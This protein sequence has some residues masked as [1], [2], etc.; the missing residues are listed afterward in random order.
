MNQADLLAIAMEADVPIILWGDPG[1][2]K[3]E[4]TYQIAEYQ[5]RLT[6]VELMSQA[7]PTDFGVPFVSD[8]HQALIK[9]RPM[10]VKQLQEAEK[11]CLFADEYNCAPRASQVAGHRMVREKIVG[12]AYLGAHVSIVLACNPPEMATSVGE[13]GPALANRLM[14]VNWTVDAH[15]WIE[16]TLGQSTNKTYPTLSEGWE[17]RIAQV[18]TGIAAF[19]QRRPQLLLAVPKEEEQQSRAWPSPRTWDLVARMIAAIESTGSDD[20]GEAVTG[21]IGAGTAQEFVVWR[22]EAD[23]PDP[24]AM[25]KDAEHCEL[26]LRGDHIYAVIYG[27]TQAVSEE[28][29]YLDAAWTLMD[30]IGAAGHV[31]AGSLTV[32]PLYKVVSTRKGS[33]VHLKAMKIIEKYWGELLK[34]MD[35]EEKSDVQ[36]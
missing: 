29:K 26:P 28:K 16:Y 4:M 1:S 2:G 25:L 10:W 12:D 34:R 18:K 11:G 15:S 7:D 32:V 14:H 6:H 9:L 22:A 24:I 23:L 8:E 21:L 19:I 31:D 36:T 30:R 20:I 3:S 35:H 33:E 17:T 5:G 13:I 27:I